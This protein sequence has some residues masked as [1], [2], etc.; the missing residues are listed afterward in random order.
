M[1]L[2]PLSPTTAVFLLVDH[3]AIRSRPSYSGLPAPPRSSKSRR[4]SQPAKKG[5]N[6]ALFGD[7]LT[8]VRASQLAAA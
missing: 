8:N 4:S 5:E 2:E 6:G 7:L 3:R 1:T